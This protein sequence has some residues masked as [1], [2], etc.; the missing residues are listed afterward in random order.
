MGKTFVNL[1]FFLADQQ[2]GI[3][4]NRYAG[5]VVTAIFQAPQPFEQDRG[6]RFFSD[7]SDNTAHKLG[8]SGPL[9]LS[10]I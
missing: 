8:F 2:R 5:T 3:P 6:G 10:L 4:L 1:A 7:V 9:R